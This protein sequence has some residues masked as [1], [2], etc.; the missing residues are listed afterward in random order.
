[1]NDHAGSLSAN[2]LARL[3]E[4][5][6][7]PKPKRRTNPLTGQQE[8]VPEVITLCQEVRCDESAILAKEPHRAKAPAPHTLDEREGQDETVDGALDQYS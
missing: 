8:F 2:R 7:H 4:R 5:Y 3:V 6:Q 1:M